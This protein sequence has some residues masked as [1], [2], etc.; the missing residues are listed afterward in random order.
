MSICANRQAQEKNQIIETDQQIIQISELSDMDFKIKIKQ[1]ISVPPHLI[2]TPALQRNT[3]S[4]CSN[5]RYQVFTSIFSNDVLMLLSLNSYI[6][7]IISWL[8]SMNDEIFTLFQLSWLANLPYI[9]CSFPSSHT[10]V[11]TNMWLN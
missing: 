5:F 1:E 8:P 2:F 10:I 3:L 4:T 7:V 11:T 6:L 9:P